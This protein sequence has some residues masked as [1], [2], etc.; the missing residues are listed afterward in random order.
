[1]VDASAGE[2]ENEELAHPLK[3]QN[4]FCKKKRIL[5]MDGADGCTRM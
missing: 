5:E 4:L 2:R 1:M 3:V